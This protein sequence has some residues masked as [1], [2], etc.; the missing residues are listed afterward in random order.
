MSLQ[1]PREFRIDGG[2]V[3]CRERQPPTLR[4]R[5]ESGR[6]TTP[7]SRRSRRDEFRNDFTSIRHENAF[8]GPNLP[9]VLGQAVFQFPKPYG[10][11]D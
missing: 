8:T 5:D 1:Q 7:G 10:F 11:H 2:I 6:K 4:E 3:F 9:D